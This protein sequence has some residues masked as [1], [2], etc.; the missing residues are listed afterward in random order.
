[1]TSIASVMQEDTSVGG[2]LN[3]SIFLKFK[4]EGLNYEACNEI[5]R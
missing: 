5:M 3:V 2:A 4:M 1:M